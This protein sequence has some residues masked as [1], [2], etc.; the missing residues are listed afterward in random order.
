MGISRLALYNELGGVSVV[1]PILLD[2]YEREAERDWRGEDGRTP[3]SFYISSFPGT[4]PYACGRAAVYSLMGLPREKPMDIE[5]FRW[6]DAGKALE[7]DFI[8]RFAAEGKLL[9]GNE[10]AGEAQTKLGDPHVWSSGA[11][12]AIILPWGWKQGHCVEVKNT[13]AE[14]MAAMRASRDQTPWSHK[15]YVRQL[16]TYIGYAHENNWAP[17]VVVCEEAWSVTTD[18]GMMGLRWCPVHRSL[19][20]RTREIQLAPPDNGTLIYASRD[21][22]RGNKLDTFSFYFD[23]DPEH[24]RAGREACCVARGLRTRGNP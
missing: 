2:A 11:V 6:M 3:T 15:K 18:T 7:M 21:P 4:D 8:R 12:D 14:K 1:D 19:E 16:K 23:Y 5:A 17:K 22:Q 24:L 20:C 13:S 10:A 9:S